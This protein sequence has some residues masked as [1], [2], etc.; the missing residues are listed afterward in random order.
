MAFKARYKV[1]TVFGTR[2]EAIKMAPVIL[3][4]RGSPETF[5]VQVAVTAQHREML[6]QVLKLFGIVPD[7]DL[8]IMQ[9]NQT[10]SE[11]ISRSIT[12]LTAILK[13]EAPDLVLV[14]GDT[15]TT[16]GGS[17][18]AFYQRIPVGH[19]EAG[20]RSGDKLNP[21]PEEINRRLT[22]VIADLHFAPLSTH[23]DNLL[24]EGVREDTIFVTG[25]TVVDAL[26]SMAARDIR[27]EESLPGLGRL[28]QTRMI[29]VT[30]HRRE[31]LGKP[32]EDICLGIRR[33]VES[34]R[35]VSVVFP[36][37]MNPRVRETVYDVLGGLERVYLT[38][39]VSYEVMVGL[40]KRA[41]LVLTDSGGLQE[42]APSLGKPV[43]VLR[44]VTERPEG[45]ATGALRLVG[46]DPDRI[47]NGV[48]TLLRDLDEYRRMAS[49]RNP[50][51]DGRAR[52]RIVKAIMYHFGLA[53][54]RPPDF[55][56]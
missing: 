3:E 55:Q 33:V 6:D 32:L 49:A 30:A 29:L 1:M 24:R 43:L 36:V 39:P 38:D 22:G 28:G 34:F 54:E 52:E 4:L 48:F 13:E 44:E 16:F 27:P 14:H 26:L 10:L 51:G 8:N 46:T 47:Y 2:P 56:S 12:G 42:E 40:M 11:I 50:Y 21:Y 18:A 41:Y 17:L 25:N 20:L 37:H 23:R 35:D 45:V 31:N 5:E 53:P 7:Y 9:E 15:S 19:V